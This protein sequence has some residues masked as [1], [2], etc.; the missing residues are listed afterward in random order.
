MISRL[1][2]A[3]W[4]NYHD[5]SL[6]FQAGTTFVVASNGVGKT[7]LVEA[8]R[9]ALFGTLSA[10]SASPV[11]V[12]EQQATA[13]VELVLPTGEL[14]SVE[15]SVSAKATRKASLPSIRVDGVRIDPEAFE[16]ALREAYK[17]E[18]AFLARLTMPAVSRED[19]PTD[20]G[21]E[22]HLGRYFGLD[23]LQQAGELLAQELKSTERQIRQIKLAHASTAHQLAELETA[24]KAGAATV[25]HTATDHLAAQA[26][27]EALRARLQAGQIRQAWVARHGQWLSQTDDLL[28]EIARELGYPADRVSVEP[29]LTA[30]I[31]DLTGL[32]Q[33][34]RIQI[35]I[36]ESRADAIAV[37]QA[38]L[39]DSHDDCPVCRRPLDET[40]VEL[41]HSANT[42]EL[43]A[44]A[45]EVAD[46]RST[47]TSANTRLASL[48]GLLRRLRE[49]PH[50]GPEP[51]EPAE[52]TPTS[53]DIE[54]AAR[55]VSGSL[56][57]LVDARADHIS[58]ER[59]LRD[60]TDSDIAMK[61]LLSLFRDE[62]NIRVALATTQATLDELLA[63]TVS[64]LATE[65]NQRWKALFEGRGDLST[66]AD[67][68][69]TRDVNGHPLPYDAFST[70]ER[71]VATIVLR[72]LVAQMATFA[73]FCWFDEP[74]EHL[75]P[76]VRR[77]VANILSRASDDNGQ[78]RQVVVTTYEE[79][80]ARHLRNRYPER[81]HLLDVRQAP[82]LGMRTSP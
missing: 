33:E 18:P 62:A 56:E 75:D 27:H 63:R 59:R 1:K 58:A 40:T 26:A 10:S 36:R 54:Q 41:A 28:K 8:A 17:T 31:E 6:D 78:L 46:L 77:Q 21:L 2:L 71:M 5:V 53:V 3:N 32:I 22:G 67:G 12:G 52:P 38:R 55:R 74:L 76:D 23:G 47:E 70:G 42:A 14:L 9:W 60:A 29:L 48:Q 49:I 50:P 82:G 4:R 66:R 16:A 65:V 45:E 24:V 68:S 30:K 20:L 43:E 35:A 79:P 61:R 25:E 81:V 73:D 19:N 37:N 39:D 69:I 13:T 34:T 44:L 80:L 64:P 7:S 51:E 57:R 11:R 72:L 15:R